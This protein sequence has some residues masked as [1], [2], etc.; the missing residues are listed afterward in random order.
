MPIRLVSEIWFTLILEN[1]RVHTG[2]SYHA[3]P[4]QCSLNWIF[5][6]LI[7]FVNS[8]IFYIPEAKYQMQDDPISRKD[9]FV[10]SIDLSIVKT[11]KCFSRYMLQYVEIDRT[12]EGFQNIFSNGKTYEK[13]TVF[14]EWLRFEL[15]SKIASQRK[16]IYWY[17]EK[18]GLN[19]STD[20]SKNRHLSSCILLRLLF[21][22]MN[23]F[24][25]CKM[26]EVGIPMKDSTWF[27]QVKL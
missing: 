26:L 25:T 27:I 4:Y 23:I 12:S 19:T 15:V 17:I 9:L 10:E 18:F 22:W 16:L 8:S 14:S 1:E 3:K 5:L 6:D 2:R 13:A 24:L 20:N 11:L 21:T 7:N